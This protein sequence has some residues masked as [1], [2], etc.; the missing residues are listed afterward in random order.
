[1]HLSANEIGLVVLGIPPMTGA[2]NDWYWVVRSPKKD[3][4]VVLFSGGYFFEVMNT[5]TNGYKDIRGVWNSPSEEDTTIY[6]FD[7]TGY[8]VWKKQSKKLQ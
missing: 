4:K 5:K 3:P 7:G 1:M 2:D 8:K 6:H